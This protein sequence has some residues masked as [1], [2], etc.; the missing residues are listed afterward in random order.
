V[1]LQFEGGRMEIKEQENERSYI[2][3]LLITPL[4]IIIT[5]NNY[6]CNNSSS[7]KK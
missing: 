3:G 4:V 6:Y 7:R 5:N 1:N 2:N